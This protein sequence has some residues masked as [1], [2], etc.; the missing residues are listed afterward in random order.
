MAAQN[1][2]WIAELDG[3]GARTGRFRPL[4]TG[5]DLT[6][7]ANTSTFTNLATFSAGLAI[8]AA[9]A[10]TGAGAMTVNTST[11]DLTLKSDDGHVITQLGD[12]S[13]S[14]KHSVRDSG[15]NEIFYVDS[16][17]NVVINGNMTVAGT[18]LVQG[19]TFQHQGAT[20]IYADN[21]IKVNAGV[22]ASGR[23]GGL[24]VERYQTANDVGSGDVVGDSPS[25]SNTAQN[26]GTTTSIVL[27]LNASGTDDAYNGAWVQI[28][29]S[30]LLG[31]QV[32]QG[33]DYNGG[34]KEMTVA[35]AWTAQDATGTV[36]VANGSPTVTGVGTAFQDELAVGDTIVIGG[37]TK[38]VSSIAS[39]TSL[40][41]DTNYADVQAGATLSVTAP[42]QVPFSIYNRPFVGWI[43][44]ESADE[45]GFIAT[46]SDP[47]AAAATI[48]AYLPIRAGTVFSSMLHNTGGDVTIKSTG[49]GVFLSMGMGGG[50]SKVSFRHNDSEMAFVDSSGKGSFASLVING[51]TAIT[52][53]DTDLS[54]VSGA[55][56]TLASAKAIKAYIDGEIAGVV[57][58]ATEL[59][60]LSDVA[61]ADLAEFDHL[62]YDGAEW[63]NVQDHTL[64][65]AAERLHAGY[66][67][68]AASAAV[69]N[70]LFVMVNEGDAMKVRLPDCSS[71][72]SFA[73]AQ[74]NGVWRTGDKA[75][76]E[77]HCNALLIEDNVAVDINDLLIASTAQDGRV[78]RPGQT[79]APGDAAFYTV[80]GYSKGKVAGNANQGSGAGVDR[81][82]PVDLHIQPP[83]QV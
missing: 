52:S 31:S 29:G 2:L 6:I 4:G 30:H 43:Y 34:S 16:D 28:T 81:V 76:T 41:A 71:G 70:A 61:L 27:D 10:I 53:I 78:T 57:S 25:R 15:G 66:D 69:N 9:Q 58:G 79:G 33:S 14:K 20:T 48:Q 17:G 5:D 67:Q 40:N 12:A 72:G 83:T 49:G 18:A 64:G 62:E 63:S 26:G 46:L 59:D 11:G 73:L 21:L 32:R 1:L 23:D 56:D 35:T 77:G 75:V 80:I 24:L 39:Q 37:V 55:D 45:F 3:G 74:I 68:A 82:V 19:A 50:A 44:D 51:S 36:S 38:V 13:G 7:R 22:G 42:G 47:G 60:E 8:A 65:A 54:E